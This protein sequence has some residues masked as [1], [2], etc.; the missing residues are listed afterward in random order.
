MYNPPPATSSTDLAIALPKIQS[1]LAM[2]GSLAMDLASLKSS[3]QAPQPSNKIVREKEV[4]KETSIK[5]RSQLRESLLAPQNRSKLLA[6]TGLLAVS[7]DADGHVVLRGPSKKGLAKALSALRRLAF[8]CQWGS[9]KLKVGALLADRPARPVSTMVV[10]L[11]A[12]SSK[13]QSHE[14]R[15]TQRIR[16]LRIG[17]QAP[18]KK[19]PGAVQCEVQGIPGLSRKHCTITLEPEKAACYVQDLST[20]GTY[21]NGKRLP[22]PPYKKPQDARVRIFHGDE[23]FFRLRSEDAEELGYVVNL[24]ELS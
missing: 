20:N 17:T 11:A 24:V 15:L 21:L 6:H 2:Q 1:V 8:H 23:L 5:M 9:S 22:R 3:L 16:K 10:R 14:S 7:L 18:Q 19:E 4:E 13:L 12:T